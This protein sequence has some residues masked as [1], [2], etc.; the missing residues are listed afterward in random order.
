MDIDAETCL[1]DWNDLAQDYKELEVRIRRVTRPTRLGLRPRASRPHDHNPRIDLD[2]GREKKSRGLG[3][4]V[5][6]TWRSRDLD[7]K[8][9]MRQRPGVYFSS[10]I[11][12]LINNAAFLI[13]AND[14]AKF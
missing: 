13:A 7:D 3:D 6:V 5:S 14:A 2:D 11:T 10:L 9:I 1:K 4:F 8:S 12:A